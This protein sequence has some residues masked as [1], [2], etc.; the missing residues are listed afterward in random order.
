VVTFTESHK[1]Q[2]TDKALLGALHKA[3]TRHSIKNHI[4][5]TVNAGQNHNSTT[6]QGK[7]P[8]LY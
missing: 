6:A 5:S 1:V 4:A 7:N 2:G 3:K 8:T